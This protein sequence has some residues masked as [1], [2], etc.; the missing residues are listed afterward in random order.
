MR[1]VCSFL[2]VILLII[3]LALP[4]VGLAQSAGQ[5][6]VAEAAICRDV[7]NREPVDGGIKFPLSVGKLSCLT[8][9][10]GVEGSSKITHVWYLGDEERFRVDLTVNGPTWRTF[11]TKAIRTGDAGSWRVDVVDSAGAVLKSIPFEVT[12]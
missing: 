6:Q 9:I 5:L 12:P 8:K 2:L 10:N 1:K 7:V 3:I 4:V 11:S